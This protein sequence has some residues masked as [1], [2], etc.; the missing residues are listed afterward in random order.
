MSGLRNKTQPMMKLVIWST[1]LKKIFQNIDKAGKCKRKFET[2][3]INPGVS[4]AVKWDFQNK[5]ERVEGGNN[6]RNER[7]LSGHSRE[8]LSP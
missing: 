7:N 1:E 3:R 5:R 8:D 4:A 6:K 2:R